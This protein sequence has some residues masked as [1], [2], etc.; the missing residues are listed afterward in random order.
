MTRRPSRSRTYRKDNPSGLWG[1]GCV[2]TGI[3]VIVFVA[4]AALKVA[5]AILGPLF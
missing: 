3:I 4:Y 1:C 2:L 5:V